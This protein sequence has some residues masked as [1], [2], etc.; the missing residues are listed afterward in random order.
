KPL[1]YIDHETGVV[2]GKD[3]I[4][5]HRKAVEELYRSFFEMLDTSRPI[6]VAVLHGCNMPDAQ[7]LAT[8]IRQEYDPAELLINVTG[9]VL[10]INTGP[11][12]LALCGYTET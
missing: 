4:R 9:P 1:V 11:G 3:R 8:R 7:Q 10:G 5:T 2:E 6:R 12:A